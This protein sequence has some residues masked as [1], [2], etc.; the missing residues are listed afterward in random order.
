M[1]TWNE[2]LEMTTLH[3]G[4]DDTRASEMSVY[5]TEEETV[6]EAVENGSCVVVVTVDTHGV[7][8]PWARL[9]LTKSDMLIN[10]RDYPEY[11]EKFTKWASK[12]VAEEVGE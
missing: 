6:A 10:L 3:V 11:Y 8:E 1:N 2:V 4:I 12:I 9:Q 5:F 7:Y